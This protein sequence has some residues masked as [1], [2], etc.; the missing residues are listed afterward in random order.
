MGI[1][2]SGL[3][4]LTSEPVSTDLMPIVD[5]GVTKKMTLAQLLGFIQPLPI[6]NLVYVASNGVDSETLADGSINYPFATVSF[7]MNA[8]TTATATNP[9]TI[10]VTGQIDD[11]NQIYWKP[12][13]SF[14]GTTQSSYINNSLPILFDA[15][16]G[17]VDTIAIY[18]Q[19]ITFN[20]LDLD[21]S[22]FTNTSGNFIQLNTVYTLGNASF[23]SS[24]TNQWTIYT[25]TSY[26]GFNFTSNN[27]YVIS[28]A[29]NTYNA[30]IMGNLSYTNLDTG[31]ISIGD[32]INSLSLTANAPLTYQP[33]FTLMGSQMTGSIS[34]SGSQCVLNMDVT[35]YVLPTSITGGATVN[36]ISIADGLLANY[37]PVN[38]VAVTPSVKG[39]LEGIDAALATAEA[40]VDSNLRYVELTGTDS[41]T[42]GGYKTPFATVSYAMTQITTNTANNP[43]TV[44]VKGGRINDSMISI[45]PF[46]S[47]QGETTGTIIN[48]SGNIQLDSSFGAGTNLKTSYISNI[49]F[50]NCS[51]DT[52]TFT[53]TASTY[54]YF[55]NCNIN[56][57]SCNA[58]NN[59]NLII[60]SFSNYIQNVTM[61]N[62][63]FI[64]FGSNY[65][66]T[67]QIGTLP[68]SSTITSLLSVSNNFYNLDITANTLFFSP[69]FLMYGS[70]FA[71][72]ITLTGS[73]CVLSTDVVS[74]QPGTTLNIGASIQ[75]LSIADGLLANY[76]PTNYTPFNSSVK[77][78]LQGIDNAI[79]SISSNTFANFLRISNNVS[80]PYLAV[81][82][83]PTTSGVIYG[84]AAGVG[85]YF[86]NANS[87]D[88]ALRQGTVTRQMLIGV[89]GSTSQIAVQNTL[90]NFNVPIYLP[91]AGGTPSP[92]SYYEQFSFVTNT[93]GAVVLSNY[94]IS[95]T[96][97]NNLIFL[98]FILISATSGGATTINMTSPLPTRFR[99][100]SNF[101]AIVQGINNT[102][103]ALSMEVSSAGFITIY[104]NTSLG[105]FTPAATAQLNACVVTIS[106]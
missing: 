99:P 33:P 13:V 56:D 70:R 100:S 86:S 34:I 82:D 106:T 60:Y 77:G 41:P 50:N 94:P 76:T 32:Q 78:H 102:A 10:M 61:N 26:Y 71:G 91:T 59:S 28:F 54:L 25:Y 63:V 51:F 89:G 93:T 31:L 30:L 9:F 22:G 87:G 62:S 58:N 46:V 8:I 7:A 18:A 88:A 80:D 39:H 90:V 12:F 4:S 3:P 1:P 20:A 23:N 53:N 96:R 81:G 42:S 85:A 64:T 97:D 47:L 66:G 98:K 68:Y 6:D 105:N 43:F 69:Q 5:G 37:T 104:G 52:S 36:L 65:Q 55:Y 84:R 73:Q 49:T 11:P 15:S 75:L 24:A 101:S 67:F 40:G 92:I 95:I 38:Y 27:C 2:I 103:T 72:S 74:Y 35:A 45:K 16:V 14:S 19:D 57:F 29:G 79:S 17:T 44:I 21:A 83:D 48:N